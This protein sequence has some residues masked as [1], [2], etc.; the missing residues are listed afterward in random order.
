MNMKKALIQQQNEINDYALYSALAHR[1]K[2]PH[3]KSVYEKI[4]QEEKTHYDFWEGIT[5]KSIKANHFLIGWYI[6][7]ASLLGFFAV[8]FKR[9]YE[10][11]ARH[12]DIL[13]TLPFQK[14][15]TEPAFHK[16]YK[17]TMPTTD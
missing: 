16:Y 7:L 11:H 8:F 9:Y 17:N 4:A 14:L 12:E 5:G 10:E 2:D 13:L 3:N 6:F 1:E 15:K